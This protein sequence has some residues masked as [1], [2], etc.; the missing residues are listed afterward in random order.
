MCRFFLDE[1]P[2]QSLDNSVV[3]VGP[4][5]SNDGEKDDSLIF[6]GEIKND[7]AAKNEV[8]EVKNEV[9]GLCTGMNAMALQPQGRHKIALYL[10]ITL[11]ICTIVAFEKHSIFVYFYITMMFY[12]YSNV[13]YNIFLYFLQQNWKIR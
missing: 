11:Q 7:N 13:L 10:K 12:V 9:D 2:G 8:G 4:V 5:V 6:V 3:F 1:K